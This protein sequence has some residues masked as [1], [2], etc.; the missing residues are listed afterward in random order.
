MMRHTT[1]ALAMLLLLLLLAAT[2]AAAQQRPD[3]EFRPSVAEPAFADGEG[4]R[5]VVRVPDAS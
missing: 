5:V 3:P 1:L 4:P 2:P